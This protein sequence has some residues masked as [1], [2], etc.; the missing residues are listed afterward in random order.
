METQVAAVLVIVGRPA[1]QVTRHGHL[2]DN[3]VEELQF[4]NQ[5]PL[6]RIDD[7]V[8][9]D[10]ESIDNPLPTPIRLK[11][12]PN[13]SISDGIDFWEPLECMLAYVKDGRV[14]TP[15]T[16][17][18]EFAVLAKKDTKKG[19]G[20]SKKTRH[21]LPKIRF[22]AWSEWWTTPSE[23]TS[24]SRPDWLGSHS[25]TCGSAADLFISEYV[26]GSSFNKVIEIYNGT[27]APVDLGFKDNV[28]QI[29]FNGSTSPGQTIPLSDT[30]AAGDV[31]VLD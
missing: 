22:D 2:R 29:Y 18:G 19:S 28:V 8:L 21:I 30:V 23:I 13:V 26:E 3:E 6:T 17:F 20:Y 11:D 14:V 27:G 7:T 31:F 4:G 5:L 1:Q 12:L 16:R 15:T 25:V 24:C 10:I 9:V